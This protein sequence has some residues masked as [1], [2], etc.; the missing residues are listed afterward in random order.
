MIGQLFG[1]ASSLP[2]SHAH[3]G[4]R[5]VV[6]RITLLASALLAILVT[7]C[8]IQRKAADS[9]IAEVQVAYAGISAQAENLAPDEARSIQDALAQ[10]KD[11]LGKGNYSATLMAAKS[12]RNRVQEL[13]NRLPD[14]QTELEAAWSKLE[15]SIPKTLDALD[16]K[17]GRAKRPATPTRRAVFDSVRTELASIHAVWGEATSAKQIGRLAEAVTKAGDVKYRALRLLDG[18]QNGS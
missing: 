17:L 10:A 6:K 16:R 5:Y 11:D 9:A 3:P 18:A 2:V 4:G 12:L 15:S 7:G 13:A 1:R 8:G 14:K